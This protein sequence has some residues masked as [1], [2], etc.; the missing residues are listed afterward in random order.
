MFKRFNIYGQ[1]PKSMYIIFFVQVI[2]RF[3]DFVVPFL[4][5]YLTTKLNLT[6]EVV[7]IIVTIGS[8]L[9]IPGSLVGGRFADK[10]GRK[11]TYIIA[12]TTAA[13]CLIPCAFI[14]NPAIVVVFILSSTFFNGAVR[15]PIS[16]IITDI[17]PPDKRKIGFSLQY[18]GINLGVS[19]GPIIAG[20]L[21]K[22]YL[23]MLF[24]GD[25]ITSFIAVLL[26]VIN[27]KETN[28]KNINKVEAAAER[29][30][31]GNIIQA[32]L[33]RPEIIAFLLIYIIYS[34]VYTQHI[35]SMPLMINKLYMDRGPQLFGLLMSV[36]ALTVITLT[37]IISNITK[38]LHTLSNVI[39]AGIL[40]AIG[41][42]MI[43]IVKSFHFF[44][45]STVL[46]TIGEILIV[47]NF[48][49]YVA[50]NS[51][52]NFRARFS[53][54]GSL[55]WALGSTIGTSLM[56]KYISMMGIDMVWPL[57]FVLS[58]ISSLLMFGLYIYTK[59]KESISSAASVDSSMS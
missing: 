32:L 35:F 14:K 22:N 23:P 36:N 40:Y 13:L 15:P 16:A 24:L 46:W 56:G 29:K 58:C 34:T 39:I 48:G 28:P 27:I 59:R 9:C 54:V 57:T 7:G 45:V 42:G 25:A 2:N 18:L 43:G 10:V 47:T 20:F 4:T 1:L 8:L 49:T 26:V 31:S 33:Q 11:K 52:A 19:F 38:K 12:Q 44:V 30:E 53:A 5:L 41:F 51:P 3:G 55:S 50:N 6:I 17:L 37:V 21:F